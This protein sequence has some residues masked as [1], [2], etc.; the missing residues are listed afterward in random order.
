MLYGSADFFGGIAARRASA[1]VVTFF[2]GFAALAVVLAGVPFVA[3]ETRSS[4]L[5][6]ATLAGAFGG[7]GAM[8]IYRALAIGPVSVASPVLG[9]TGLA[10]PV[11]VG[12][13]LGERPSLVAVAGLVLAPIAIVLL[14]RSGNA[15][16]A[17][18]DG[19]PRRVLIPALSAGVVAGFFLVFMGRIQL[20]TVRPLLPPLR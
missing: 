9:I 7:L 3:G 2:S 5:L 11:I 14:S 17:A 4:D 12:A 16:D 15:D 6:W 8:L 1:L 18:H 13:A 20:S 10:L 19:D